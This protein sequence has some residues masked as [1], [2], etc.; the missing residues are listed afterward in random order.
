MANTPTKKLTKSHETHY[1]YLSPC[2]KHSDKAPDMRGTCKIGD[3]E[4]QIAAWDK[5]DINGKAYLSVSLSRRI[6]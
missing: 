1:G 4:F 5:A 2:P 3:T 6:G